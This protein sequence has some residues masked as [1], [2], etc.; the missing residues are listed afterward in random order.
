MT[1]DRVGIGAVESSYRYGVPSR[2]I[3]LRR[4]GPVGCQY[5]AKSTSRF[6]RVRLSLIFK[7]CGGAA[8]RILVLLRRFAVT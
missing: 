1:A 8:V 6:E 2:S 3:H 7:V 5:F 4:T